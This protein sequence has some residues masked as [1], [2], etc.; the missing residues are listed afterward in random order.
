MRGRIMTSRCRS[1]ELRPVVTARGSQLP[2][3]QPRLLQAASSPHCPVPTAARP[4]APALSR[5]APG[6]FPTETTSLSSTKAG[7]HSGIL[8]HIGRRAQRHSHNRLSDLPGRG[9]RDQRPV[10]LTRGRITTSRCRS[11]ELKPVVTARG[12]QLRATQPRWLQAASSPHFPVPMDARPRVAT[13][14][15]SA[16]VRFPTETTSL[17]TTKVGPHSGMPSAHQPV[18]SNSRLTPSAERMLDD[19]QA[20]SA[21]WLRSITNL[22][23]RISRILQRAMKFRNTRR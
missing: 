9:N 10:V 19:V 14:S 7:P 11:R 3:I 5:S 20:P 15:R 22:P 17:S 12:S 23:I 1:R 13:S 2:A 16:L 18:C 21:E 4:Q 8:L 6:H